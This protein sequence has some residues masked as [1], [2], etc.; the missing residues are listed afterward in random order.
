MGTP[1]VGAPS[2]GMSTPPTP[3]P[4]PAP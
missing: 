2:D 3:P 4:T 1:P